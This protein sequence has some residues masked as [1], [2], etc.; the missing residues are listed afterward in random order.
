MWPVENSC[1]S[2]P[3]EQATRR[4]IAP[5]ESLSYCKRKEAASAF[6]SHARCPPP[7][8]IFLKQSPRRDRE[9]AAEA[10]LWGKEY[11]NRVEGFLHL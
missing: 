5:S 8:S 9:V 3:F 7:S 6:L 11:L 1:A 4:R 10:L 2:V